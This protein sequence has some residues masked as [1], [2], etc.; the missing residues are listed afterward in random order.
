M[1]ACGYAAYQPL[2]PATGTPRRSL[3]DIEPKPA[4]AVFRFAA[5]GDTR[6]GHGAHR[7]IVAGVMSSHPALVLQTGDLVSDS[8]VEEQ[9]VTFDAITK[10]MRDA[11]PYYPARGNHDNQGGDSFEKYVP[12]QDV[13]RE[14]FYYSFEKGPIHF[15]ALDTAGDPITPKSP[16]YKWISD[17]MK[18][19][20]ED[21][22]FIIPFYHKAIF[23]VGPH[24]MQ[25]DV[26][27]LRPILH[28]L[29]RKYDVKLA[30]QGHDHLYYRTSR[31]GIT[32]IVTG[33]GGAPLYKTRYAQLGIQ[34]DVMEISHHF[35]VA[36]VFAD[37][38][39]VSAYRFDRSALDK[40]TV[41]LHPSQTPAE[42]TEG[43]TTGAAALRLQAPLAP[44][45]PASG[46]LPRVLSGHP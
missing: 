33:G 10:K 4:D 11:I 25:S 5:Y 29:F 14:G 17:D 1:C 38:V 19:A 45:A 31:D 40:V 30:F 7:D 8:S 22:K 18:K 21:G 34:G 15:L 2:E 27:E 37:R 20:R 39:T 16:Q 12:T 23:S 42:T 41:L 28:D 9:W 35:C 3:P 44:F 43:G 6:D 13:H 24:A 36:D 26:W 46:F 32:Y